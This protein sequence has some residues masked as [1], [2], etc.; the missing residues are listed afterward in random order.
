M[1]GEEKKE[2]S[3][4]RKTEQEALD[5]AGEKDLLFDAGGSPQTGNSFIFYIIAESVN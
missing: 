2:G 3:S 1:A 4:Q 5:S